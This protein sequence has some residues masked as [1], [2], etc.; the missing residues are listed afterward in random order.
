MD[1]R[2]RFKTILV[3]LLFAIII[4][5]S[6]LVSDNDRIV[7]GV[8]IILSVIYLSALSFGIY[9]T[10]SSYI[11]T[12]T[13]LIIAGRFS[14][15]SIKIKDI[16]NVRRFDYDDKK[17]LVRTFGAEGVL[18]NIGYYSSIRHKKMYFLTSRDTNWVMIE[19]NDNKKFVISP[20]SLYMVELLKKL[21]S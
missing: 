18:G 13:E 1:K 9:K 19:T 12:D 7:I 17:G 4:T 21:I 20:D 3:F 2:T 16:R 6:F 15:T 5:V 8:S 11:I 10:P 14:R